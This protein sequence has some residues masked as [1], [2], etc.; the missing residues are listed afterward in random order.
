VAG[1]L[2]NPCCTVCTL[3]NPCYTVCTLINP[4]YTVC[5]L[6][7]H[8]Y[9]VCTLTNPCDTVCWWQMLI[10]TAEGE[11]DAS[12]SQTLPRLA[13]LDAARVLSVCSLADD[14]QVR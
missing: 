10:G 13:V 3:I 8:C 1:T 9:T 5:T 4:C 6:I 11:G 14:S 2:I 7:H 12:D